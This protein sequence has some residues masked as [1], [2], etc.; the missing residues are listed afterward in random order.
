M[1][2]SRSGWK[3]VHVYVCTLVV[4]VCVCV[5]K[6]EGPSIH[7]PPFTGSTLPYSTV[8]VVHL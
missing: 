7:G 2:Y 6:V 5:V 4:R 8:T 3:H 1:I